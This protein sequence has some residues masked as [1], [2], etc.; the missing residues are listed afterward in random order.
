MYSLVPRNTDVVMKRMFEVTS[1]EFNAMEICKNG[2]NKLKLYSCN[3]VVA[4]SLILSMKDL[5]GIRLRKL[6]P[7]ILNKEK[8]TLP[9]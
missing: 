4:P 2:N 5:I 8:C 7:Q 3:F 6:Y 9:R 1:E